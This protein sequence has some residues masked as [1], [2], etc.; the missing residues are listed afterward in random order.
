[1]YTNIPVE[2]LSMSAELVWGFL[3][4]VATMFSMIFAAR[5]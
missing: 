3:T 2:S 5:G 1:M 4:V